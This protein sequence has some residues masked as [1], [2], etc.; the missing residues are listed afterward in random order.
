MDFWVQVYDLLV[1]YMSEGIG[2]QLGNFIGKYVYYDSNNNSSIWRNYMRIRLAIDVRVPLK[3]CKKIHN[4]KVTSFL[5]IS[6]T[7]D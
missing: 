3:R 5:F 2:R 7:S 4:S 1:G 6:S